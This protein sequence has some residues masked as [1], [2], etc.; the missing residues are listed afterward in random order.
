[1]SAKKDLTTNEPEEDKDESPK[2]RINKVQCKQVRE[3]MNLSSSSI[4]ELERLCQELRFSEK[5]LV[6]LKVDEMKPLICVY[7]QG[8]CVRCRKKKM[9]NNKGWYE[10]RLNQL[11]P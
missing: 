5:R 1:M 6:S 7:E 9:A 4:T 3:G 8:F 2:S 11:Q 10:K